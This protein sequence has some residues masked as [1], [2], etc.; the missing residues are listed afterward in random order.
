MDNKFFTFIQNNNGGIFHDNDRVAHF[1]IIEA[2]DHNE[3]NTIA[4]DVVG[5]YFDGMMNDIDCPCCGDRW[6]RVDHFDGKDEPMVYGEKLTEYNG[7][8]KGDH[9]II[10]RKSEYGSHTRE[11]VALS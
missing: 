11:K 4:K 8:F 1:V 5:I 9:V 2:K 10:Y 7:Y 6:Y 3:A